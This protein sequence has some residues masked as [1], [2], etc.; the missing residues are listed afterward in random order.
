[1][2]VYPFL[3]IPHICRF[4]YTAV[5]FT[6]RKSTPKMR[7]FAKKIGQNEPRFCVL[8]AKKYTSSRKSTPPPVVA[9]VT[10]MSYVPGQTSRP[11]QRQTIFSVFVVA[12]QDNDNTTSSS[13]AAN[14]TLEPS[15]S[16][17]PS[18]QNHL[19]HC[20]GEHSHN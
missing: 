17:A 14:Q 18:I 12:S 15:L 9:V 8:H 5:S 13:A 3:A 10:N 2:A 1:M 20:I 16:W 7:E 6:Y 4:L 11:P 19:T